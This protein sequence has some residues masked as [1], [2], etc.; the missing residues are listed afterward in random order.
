MKIKNNTVDIIAFSSS[1]ICAVHCA[2]IPLILSFSSLGSLHFLGNPIIEWTFIA[3]G[4]V[5]V[6]VSLW[7][8][9][10]KTHFKLKPLLYALL[11]FSFILLGRLDLNEFWEVSNTVAGASLVSLAHYFNWKLLQTKE[12]HKH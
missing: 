8:S 10:K 4:I 3:F 2:T 9:Y 6:L 12:N 5:F 11:G 1:L 7:P